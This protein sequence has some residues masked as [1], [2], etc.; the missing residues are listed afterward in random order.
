MALASCLAAA[1][2]A[3]TPGKL[4][5]L[6]SF[7]R[8]QTEV[9]RAYPPNA[10][11]GATAFVATNAGEGDFFRVGLNA[12]ENARLEAFH[13]EHRFLVGVLLTTTTSGYTTT[14][15]RIGL[16]RL[17]RAKRQFCIRA[18]IGKPK[19]GQPVVNHLWFAM[20]IVSL[21]AD[22]Y[23]IDEF[24]WNIPKAWVLRDTHGKLLAV[25]HEGPNQEGKPI[26]T[27]RAK[28]CHV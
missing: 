27:G 9:P 11:T 22:P 5:H 18:A 12:G 23:R 13:F 20:H 4:Q 19:P 16:Q 25:S 6:R 3:A 26:T 10:P 2:T 17:P 15:Q 21:S 28:P 1:A 8:T 24:H 14:I 7:I